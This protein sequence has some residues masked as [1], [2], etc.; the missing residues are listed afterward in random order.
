MDTMPINITHLQIELN[1]ENCFRVSA[2]R[3]SLKKKN[4]GTQ[5]VRNTQMPV[6][7]NQYRLNPKLERNR[8][9]TP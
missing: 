2:I 1:F 5:T 8:R 6:D 7:P 9:A 4:A 3:N